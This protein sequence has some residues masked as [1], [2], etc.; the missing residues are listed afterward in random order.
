MID[1]FKAIFKRKPKVAWLSVADLQTA[2]VASPPLIIDV[3]SK[4]EFSF[5]G[6]IADSVLM[7]LP[8]LQQDFATIQTD[9]PIVCV[10]RMGRRGARAGNFLLAQGFTDVFSLDGGIQAWKKAG[11]PL[12]RKTLGGAVR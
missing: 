2:L 7:P 11:L 12:K 6:H 5:H 10:D 1:W 3:R 9:R 4:E 8:E